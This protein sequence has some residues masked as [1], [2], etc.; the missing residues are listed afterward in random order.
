MCIF[1][2]TKADNIQIKTIKDRQITETEYLLYNGILTSTCITKLEHCSP[3][4]DSIDM[5]CPNGNE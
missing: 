1:R 3:L 2:R 5:S 4:I